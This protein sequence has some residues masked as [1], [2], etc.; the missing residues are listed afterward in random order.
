MKKSVLIDGNSLLNRAFFATPHFTTKEGFPTN[1][2]YGFIKLFLKIL[3]DVKPEYAV[4]AFDMHA[5][6]FRHKMYDKYKATRKGMPEELA[7]QMPVLKE[8]LSLMG[9][10]MFEKEG[11]EADDIIGTLSRRFGEAGVNSFVYTGDRDSYQLVNEYTEVCFTRKGVSDLLCLTNENF[12]E[13]IGLN[14]P[15]IID[16][17][18]LMG[19]SSDNIPGV[20]GIG[21]KM[22][23][24][25][26]GEYGSL[27]EIYARID[28]IGGATHKKLE[29][30]RD[31]AFLSKQLA[32]IDTTV[33]LNL[34]LE[35]CRVEMPF[36]AAV[37]RKFASLE[38]R[39]LYAD[40][41]LYKKEDAE[42]FGNGDLDEILKT[43]SNPADGKIK[44]RVDEKKKTEIKSVY[45][46]TEIEEILTKNSVFSLVW[47]KTRRLYADG[48]EYDFPAQKDLFSIGISEEECVKILKTLFENKK[49]TVVLYNAKDM[50]HLLHDYKIKCEAAFEDVSIL[51]YLVDYT[52]K[53]ETLDFLFDVY[54]YSKNTPAAS[55]YGLFLEFS[56]K[57]K[58]EGLEKLYN[59]IEKPI[60]AVLCD[61]ETEGVCINEPALR[62]LGKEY[63]S[64]LRMLCDRIHALAGDETFNVNSTQQLSK[65]LFEKLSLPGGKKNKNGLYSSGADVLEKLAG[66]HE[67]AREIL[68]YRKIQKLNSTYVEGLK[69]FIENGKIHTTYTQIVTSTGRLSSKNPNLQNIPIRTEEGREIRKLFVASEGNVLLDADYSQIE[70]RLMAHMSDCK[71]LIEAYRNGKDIHRETAAKVY[72]IPESEVTSTM[73]RNAKAVNFG[74]IYGESAFGLARNLNIAPSDAADFIKRYFEAY[75]AVKEFQNNMVREAK[76]NGY[77]ATL[78]GR[79]REIPEL[80]SSNYNVRQFGERAAMNMPLQG[81]SAD[82]IKIA[83]IAV[84]K[85]LK[86]NDM[87]T[88]L[89]LQVHDELVLDAPESEADKAAKILKDCMENAVRLNVPLTVEVTRGKSWYDAK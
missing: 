19:D 8:C 18:S 17:K 62:L 34:N 2:I 39:L 12:K 46:S 35:D 55:L 89:I 82:I 57:A 24:K 88:R 21:E 6:T 78:F 22:A 40:E 76:E 3:N 5:P 45:S 67:I 58:R 14:P 47:D 56:E 54:G 32:T 87:K 33:E 42:A 25:L 72:D 74:I 66:E 79:K 43:E 41:K 13:T 20:P 15:Q 38:F 37:R 85:E 59:D 81:S 4:V 52:G 49:N 50:L 23:M 10:K 70:L 65:I 60:C 77:V 11:I 28:E 71:E 68:H 7:V 73:R 30:N 16:L 48:K 63:A 26:L 27:E 51:K 64:Q 69:P 36:S 86:N 31:L 9:V 44:S 83:M 61:M 53:E 84:D 75:P 29:E 1:G 80:K